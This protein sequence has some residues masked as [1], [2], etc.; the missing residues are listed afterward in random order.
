[1]KKICYPGFLR[2]FDQ[3]KFDVEN[4]VLL[5]KIKKINNDAKKIWESSNFSKNLPNESEI[6]FINLFD[7]FESELDKDLLSLSYFVK[8]C[9]DLL[10]KKNKLLRSLGL[11]SVLEKFFIKGCEVIK[12]KKDIFLN[13]HSIE[14]WHPF[15]RV[16]F[17][18][19]SNEVVDICRAPDVRRM[20]SSFEKTAL[21]SK[22]S[23]E[24]KVF[25]LLQR[26]SRL[27]VLRFDVR[28][29]GLTRYECEKSLVKSLDEL[30]IKLSGGMF[31]S[32][33]TIFPRNC[34]DTRLLNGCV[35]HVCC[36]VSLNKVRGKESDILSDLSKD[37]EYLANRDF[38]LDFI[39]KKISF[40]SKK[41]FIGIKRFKS[42][43][44]KVELSDFCD[45]M[46]IERSILKPMLVD[47]IN[48]GLK[49][50]NNLK[51]KTF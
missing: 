11:V 42:E 32:I 3:E 49:T 16:I 34:F 33:S 12:N 26:E 47:F 43:E 28:S 45:F 19:E 8:G 44:L 6:D 13:A 35:G 1:M 7:D 37:L 50:F 17:L 24:D 10:M 18:F 5:D 25:Y 21:T 41:S 31:M 27:L 36:F 29:I 38:Y 2:F 30:N 22:A 23:I 9:C 20:A 48:G 15:L 46:T 39:D 51:I 40:G 4:N 14:A